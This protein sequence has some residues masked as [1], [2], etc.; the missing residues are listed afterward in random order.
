[1]TP[2]QPL[3][4]PRILLAYDLSPAAERAVALLA[5]TTW[6]AGTVLRVMTSTF[7]VGAGLSS[8]ATISEARGR[9]RE[10]RARI[11]LAQA[12]VSA[13]LLDACLAVERRLLMADQS[14]QSSPPLTASPPT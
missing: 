14:A 1:M 12:R 10:A 3:S 4:A 11:E 8:F 9:V 6:P 13:G 5:G 2:A 7:G